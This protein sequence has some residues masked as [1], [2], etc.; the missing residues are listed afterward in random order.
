[1]NTKQI[2]YLVLCIA[3]T[4]IPNSQFIPFLREH[5]FDLNQFFQQLFAN[6]ISSLFAFDVIVSSVVLWAFV[7]FEGGRLRMRNRW[8]YIAA[9]LVGGVSMALPLFLLVRQ[10][11]IDNTTE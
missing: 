1:M 11:R 9:N 3:G 2:I 4:I 7:F 5:G 10:F 8:V 6:K